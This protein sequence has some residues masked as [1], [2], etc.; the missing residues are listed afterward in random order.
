MSDIEEEF[1]ILDDIKAL[2]DALSQKNLPSS[3]PVDS[4]A[5]SKK[6]K[7]FYKTET[8]DEGFDYESSLSLEDSS[9]SETED[10]EI[11][12]EEDNLQAAFKLNQKL[13]EI[14]ETTK[15]ELESVLQECRAKKKYV[16][17]KL[18]TTMSSNVKVI[19]TTAGMP[20]FKDKQ[21]FPAPKNE[22]ARFK[23]ARGELQIINIRNICRWTRK[24]R[25]ILCKAINAEA[26]AEIVDP[27]HGTE[28][29][30]SKDK[31]TKY[32]S[33]STDDKFLPKNY[34]DLIGPLGTREFDWLKIAAT[35][36]NNKHSGDECQVMWNVFL[37]PDI[38]KISWTK[39]EDSKMLRLA[40]KYNFQNWDG[41]AREL[42]THRTGYQ[43]FIRHNVSIR[44]K[45][46]TMRSWSKAEDQKLSEIVE[47]VKF[48]DFVPWGEVA[49]YMPNRTKQQVYFRWM[50]SLAPH[51][52]KGRFTKEEDQILL[53]A[54]KKFGDNFKRISA[55][56]MP[57]RSTIQLSDHYHTLLTRKVC[58]TG[59]TLEDDEK[60]IELHGQFRADWSAIAQHFTH[61]TRV[62]LRH[63]YSAL[64]RYQKKGITWAQIPRICSTSE[65]LGL[66]APSRTL[67][68]RKND[69]Y[70]E[71]QYKMNSENED[72][73]G[74]D[75]KME[76]VD[77]QLME[78]FK[79][80]YQPARPGRRKKYYTPEELQENTK[81]LHKILKKLN[82]NL[83]MP[84]Q[85]DV[86]DM[87]EKDKQLLASFREYEKKQAL[88]EEYRAANIE[89]LRQRMFGNDSSP[90]SVFVP[91]VP[92]S[93]KAE[94]TT[95]TCMS[96][97]CPSTGDN[98]CSEPDLIF[99]T[100]RVIISLIGG[101]IVQNQFESI[102]RM[103]VTLKGVTIQDEWTQSA[104]PRSMINME[105]FAAWSTASAR[106]QSGSSANLN[107][108]ISKVK[109]K[110]ICSVDG[111]KTNDSTRGDFWNVIEP[112]YSTL[113]GFRNMCT[114]KLLF[115]LQEKEGSTY[116]GQRKMS[117][118][119]H[120]ALLLLRDRLLKLF[121]YPIGMAH[122][123][124]PIVHENDC[125]FLHH[126]E[127]TQIQGDKRKQQ[128]TP[129]FS[130][131]IKVDHDSEII[132]GD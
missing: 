30:T 101:D 49:S 98:Y 124:P 1:V 89:K 122:T 62:Q 126:G 53:D 132:L 96:I 43:C 45:V 109:L 46:N 102:S 74:T 5:D 64:E 88:E 4:P 86:E 94:K 41:I 58:V 17:E 128:A 79:S 71:E 7:R 114:S 117:R 14:L 106:N 84:E 95:V 93:S 9:S 27:L 67:T 100:P 97:D 129:G 55:F 10:L 36:F 76:S 50:Y 28:S 35:D 130:K 13:I 90:G 3:R 29:S 21:Q 8:F 125:I 110:T 31:S 19:N 18:E 54:V 73:K 40:K 32:E 105:K 38:N 91:S 69:S 51:L 42:K 87:T 92:S 15:A 116:Q 99:D 65:T 2:E 39:E 77:Q 72:I 118:N 60:L 37:H 6:Q 52:K 24:D 112:C 120:R 107:K 33:T 23:A 82:A 66:T 123:F 78:Y 47:K 81:A 111:N 16:E 75:R 83:K 48:G 104:H 121:M 115:D 113:L 80:F 119:G 127:N 63:R 56:V 85:L 57:H 26:A 25:M 34:R 20:Y 131:R 68:S 103:L 12:S 59:W 108:I 22:D 11:V 44:S 61:K 70:L